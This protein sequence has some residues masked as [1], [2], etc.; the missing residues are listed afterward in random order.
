MQCLYTLSLP[1]HL[2]I[3]CRVV[4]YEGEHALFLPNL[5]GEFTAEHELACVALILWAYKCWNLVAP[6]WPADNL[7]H[8]WDR[9]Q[10]PSVQCTLWIWLTAPSSSED[11]WLPLFFDASSASHFWSTQLCVWLLGPKPPIFFQSAEQAGYT[12]NMF[13]SSKQLWIWLPNSL[14]HNILYSGNWEGASVACSS[15]D[16]SSAITYHKMP[17]QHL[18]CKCVC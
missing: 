9:L 4:K 1:C 11:A 5:Q 16:A 2:V 6:L 18:Q 12:V 10:L 14:L 7:S 3:V 15:Q 8:L 17:A 13:S